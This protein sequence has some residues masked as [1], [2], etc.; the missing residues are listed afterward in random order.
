MG[1]INLYG[2]VGND[3]INWTDMLGLDKISLEYTIL[4]SDESELVENISTWATAKIVR[5]IEEL[6][7]NAIKAVGKYSPDGLG[8]CNCIQNLV[9]YAHAV[10]AGIQVSDNVILKET[11]HSD[12]NDLA[13]KVYRNFQ[14]AR[15]L[16]NL[17]PAKSRKSQQISDQASDQYA[18]LDSAIKSF[19]DLGSLMC[20]NGKITIIGCNLQG[21]SDTDKAGMKKSDD[22][23]KWLEE[24]WGNDLEV[25]LEGIGEISPTPSGWRRD[26]SK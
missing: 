23:E 2:F 14:K 8:N 21:C 6:N 10:N 9:I 13:K 19:L 4:K 5:S 1:G 22:Y 26:P 15:N 24:T 25:S 11:M 7:G 12:R 16:R 3:G 20:K 18:E 17:D